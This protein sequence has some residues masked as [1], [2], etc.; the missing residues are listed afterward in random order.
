MPFIPN[1]F[2]CILGLAGIALLFSS[3]PVLRGGQ[4]VE[5]TSLAVL[6][7]GAENDKPVFQARLTLQF[8]TPGKITRSKLI[9]YSAKT[10]IQG[11]YTFTN[12]PKG[13]IHLMVT[14]D[15]R[16]SYGKKLELKEDNQFIEVKLRKPQPVL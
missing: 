10:S 12:I 11:R 6:V 4:E 9:T 2:R 13:T 1:K 3:L 8:R 15:D 14:A 5:Y 7:K 16:Q